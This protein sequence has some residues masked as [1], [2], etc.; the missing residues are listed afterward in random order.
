VGHRTEPCSIPVCISLGVDISPS[1]ETSNF[2]RERKEP[3]SLI[4]L[5]EDFESDNLDNT[6]RCHIRN[7]FFIFKNATAIDMLLLK[8]KVTWPVSLIH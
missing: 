3:I 7:A 8:F 6:S 2:L 1:A 4:R 5:L